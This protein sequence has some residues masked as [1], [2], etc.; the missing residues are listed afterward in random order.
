MGFVADKKE[1]VMSLLQELAELKPQVEMALNDYE[2]TGVSSLINSY[3]RSLRDSGT[4]QETVCGC[5]ISEVQNLRHTLVEFNWN[6]KKDGAAPIPVIAELVLFVFPTGKSSV[7]HDHGSSGSKGQPKNSI[8]ILEGECR[9]RE[10][11][12][13]NGSLHPNSTTRI[14]RLGDD[15]FEF[16]G[17]IHDVASNQGTRVIEVHFYALAQ[18]MKFEGVDHKIRHFGPD[19]QIIPTTY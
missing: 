9:S 12:E 2:P 11:R 5:P 6:M 8:L 15:C 3:T 16:R 4:W 19:G 10:Y 14:I 13:N 18:R 7:I 17:L 1:N